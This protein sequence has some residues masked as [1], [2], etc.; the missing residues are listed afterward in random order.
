MLLF[1]ALLVFS[2]SIS[3]TTEGALTTPNP[4]KYLM[5]T[6]AKDVWPPFVY[7][8]VGFDRVPSVSATLNNMVTVKCCSTHTVC[9]VNQLRFIMHTKRA[10]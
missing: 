1:E 3:C 10:L 4:R 9:V 8:T 7:K 2:V 5:T 6:Q